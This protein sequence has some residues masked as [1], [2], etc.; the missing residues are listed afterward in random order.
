MLSRA[1]RGSILFFLLV[2]AGSCGSTDSSEPE[3]VFYS[4][5]VTAI[6]EE[7]GVA[8]PVSGSFEAGTGIEVNASPAPGWI[9]KQWN[10][11]MESDQNPLTLTMNRD[12]SIEAEFEYTGYELIVHIDG[13][14]SV[15]QDIIQE[16]RDFFDENV[17]VQ[18]TAVPAEGWQFQE[19]QGDITGADNPETIVMDQAK[20][21]TAVFTRK[22]F[23]LSV[24]A[25]GEG[26]YSMELLS[27]TQTENGFLFESQV[28]LTAEPAEGWVFMRWEGGV[29]SN[30]NP[31]S[32]SIQQDTEIT[33]VFEREGFLL[34]VETDGEGTV[35][36]KIIQTKS[37]NYPFETVVELTAVPAEGW[38]FQEWQGDITGADNPETIVMDQA[39]EVTAVFTRKEYTLSVEAEGEGTYSMEL[40]SGTQTENGFL[41][42]SQVRLTATPDNGWMFT[43]W[44][45]DLD[46][47]INPETVIMDSDKN[48][49]VQFEPLSLS[50]D[51]YL[52]FKDN[53]G[54][55]DMHFGQSQNPVPLRRLAPP[56]PPAGALNAYFRFEGTNFVRDYR[57]DSETDVIWE[58]RYQAGN[59]TGL[60][61]SWNLN[62]SEIP[63]SLILKDEDKNVE[64][65]M[66]EENSVDL[67]DGEDGLLWIRF[68]AN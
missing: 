40:L 42:E 57:V 54:S 4:L 30:E 36:Q 67:T 1:I 63:G 25:E 68:I 48:V 14:G 32:F 61:L 64:I 37:T 19:W 41:F 8:E 29:T 44:N 13:E 15:N 6:P 53:I 23:T 35:Q 20:E 50:Y 24:E 59:G 2:L 49:T 33:A 26:T 3:P 5:S 34:T 12:L 18:L 27:G 28:R 39:K 65:D 47:N 9:F 22:E 43:G 51:V 60:S 55:F 11:D 45:G 62:S 66:L 31:Y 7:G 46:G 16:K 38:Q 52:T 21:V 10:G 58:L 17:I 56:P